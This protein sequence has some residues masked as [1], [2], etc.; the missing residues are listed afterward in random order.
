M[1][2][3]L[4]LL[5]PWLDERLASHGMSPRLQDAM[6]H[7]VLGGGKRLR[8]RLVFAS[9]EWAG[10]PAE[11]AVPTAAAVELLHA[12]S[13]VHDDLPAMDNADTRRGQA[14]CHRAFD[15]ATAILVGDALQTEAFAILA[16]PLTHADAVVRC[17]LLGALAQAVGASGM[18]AGQ[19]QDMQLQGQAV[20]LEQVKTMHAL[21]TGALITFSCV[22][23]GMLA[24][25]SQARYDSLLRLGGLLGQAFQ[26]VD[27]VLDATQS[28][29][30]LGKPAQDK[31]TGKP[32]LVQAIGLPAAQ[33]HVGSLQEG[34]ETQLKTMAAWGSALHEVSRAMVQRLS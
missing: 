21:K 24:G 9:S 18:V 4:E 13:L 28:P 32:T 25:V 7:A 15:E 6:R 30:L 23:G 19:M 27:D 22:A 29:S 33:V 2:Q 17:R 10:L 5:E 26:A 12:Y 8:A 1:M 14:S 20:T 31:Q 16:E 3:A 11:Q 34:I